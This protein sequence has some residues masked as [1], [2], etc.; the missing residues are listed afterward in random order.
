[1]W[2]VGTRQQ[3]SV[4]G[5]AGHGTKNVGVIGGYS[6]SEECVR[7]TT[8]GALGQDDDGEFIRIFG[9]KKSALTFVFY[10]NLRNGIM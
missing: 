10:K 1:M 8:M 7:R 5:G 9:E 6:G 2:L 4:I 3:Y